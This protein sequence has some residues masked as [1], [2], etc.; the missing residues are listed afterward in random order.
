[1]YTKISFFNKF[2]FYLL[3]NL[4]NNRKWH[5]AEKWDFLKEKYN[6]IYL[7]LVSIVSP[8]KKIIKKPICK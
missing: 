2:I 7:I 1:M 6:E 5:N 8:K 4:F 3:S